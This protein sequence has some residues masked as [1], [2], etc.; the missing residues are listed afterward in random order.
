MNTT[1]SI[2]SQRSASIVP[3]PAGS[4]SIWPA[5]PPRWGRRLGR[6]LGSLGAVAVLLSW[7]A[8]GAEPAGEPTTGGAE[9]H[10]GSSVSNE[11]ARAA[12]SAEMQ[13]QRESVLSKAMTRGA[14]TGGMD[15]H[16]DSLLS[17]QNS[18]QQFAHPEFMLRLFLS[19]TLAVGCAWVVAWHPRRVHAP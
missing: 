13:A 8:F 2:P 3:A 19:L 5:H 1:Q 7:S 15:P 17:I 6:A 4:G 12:A 18:L 14:I 16:G 9:A 10:R 11:T